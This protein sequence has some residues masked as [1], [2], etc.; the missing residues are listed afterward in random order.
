MLPTLVWPCQI[1][2]AGEP[3][4]VHRAYAA[5]LA[6]DPRCPKLFINAEPGSILTG[7]V[8]DFCGH[9]AVTAYSAA[10]QYTLNSIV[11]SPPSPEKGPPS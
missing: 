7:A 6:S 5:W 1:P 2:F 8:S 10:G 3:A 9:L 4:D 11:G